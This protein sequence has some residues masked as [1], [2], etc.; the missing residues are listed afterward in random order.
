MNRHFHICALAALT[1]VLTAT[2]VPVITG[3]SYA[4]NI[5]W[6]SCIMPLC[7]TGLVNTVTNL[8]D[9]LA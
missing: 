5:A 6:F 3:H 8:K 7:V 2:A 4:Y 9:E 1:V